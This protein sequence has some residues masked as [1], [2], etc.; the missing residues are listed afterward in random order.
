M[1]YLEWLSTKTQT[2]WW[3]DSAIPSEIDEAIQNGALGITTNP[4]LTYKALQ[5]DPEYWKEDVSKIPEKI[6]GKLGIMQRTLS[7][8]LWTGW[9]P[10]ETYG[11]RIKSDRWF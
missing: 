9:A 6:T 1:N 2:K 10:L 7:Q 3:H 8:F 11:S 5:A 4:I